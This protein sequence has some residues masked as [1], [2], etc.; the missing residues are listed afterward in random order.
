[1]IKQYQIKQF[2][3]NERGHKVTTTV[4]TDD[5]EVVKALI[6]GVKPSENKKD[7]KT[8][9]TKKKPEAKNSKKD[10]VIDAEFTEIKSKK[11]TGNSKSKKSVNKNPSMKP[12]SLPAPKKKEAA[13]P[14]KGKAP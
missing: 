2:E 3:V 8:T 14:N 7:S 9:S 4:S 12:K 5:V 1:M 6:G 11:K 10:G 13:K